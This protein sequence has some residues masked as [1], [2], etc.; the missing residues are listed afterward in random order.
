[1]I[2]LRAASI[3]LC[4]QFLQGCA[5]N[6]YFQKDALATAAENANTINPEKDSVWV[7]AGRHYDRNALHRFFWGNHNRHLWTMPVKVPVFNRQEV[8]AGLRI[9]KEGGGFQ[10]TS[11]HMQDSAGRAYAFRSIDKDP[12]HVLSPFWQS[13]FVAN[14]VR[15]QTSAANPFGMLLVP[16]LARAAGILH[17]N[18]RLFYVSQ[19]DTTFGEFSEQVQ[20]RLFMLEEKFKTAADIPE[21]TRGVKGFLDSDE[22]LRL[23]YTS[24]LYH[25]DQRAF[26]KARLLDLLL[27]DW[28]R[29]KGQW[30]WAVTQHGNKTIFNPIPKDRDQVLLKM[31]D[32]VIPFL[33]TSKIMV[34]KFY[35][36]SGKYG[37]VKALLINAQFVDERLLHELPKEEWLAIARQMQQAISDEVIAEAVRQLPSPI[38][39]TIGPEVTANLKKRRDHLPEAAEKMYSLLAKEV[40]IPGTDEAEQFIVNRLP[41]G[42]T[43]VRVY[44]R[45][46]ETLQEQLLYERIFQPKET[47][48][49]RLHGLA[50]ND[51]FVVEGYV[52]K[53]I[54]LEI[55]G[56]L[57]EDNIVDRSSVRGW[58]K[59]TAVFD[60]KRGN[61]IVPGTETKDRTTRDVSVHAYDREGN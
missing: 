2:F 43:H 9:I 26:A 27:G 58:K 50:G 32:G 14:I 57:G 37:D 59:T 28:D 40:T 56:G 48:L 5:D 52:D 7:I 42:K 44:R 1:M 38:R 54:P 8:A 6:D 31:K 13:T 39:K 33:A 47:R 61:K 53:A 36:F 46:S 30:D 51:E 16:P 23:R 15:D 29:H 18:P 55:V 21:N 25:F 10:T 60:T 3:L 35:T 49:I 19:N 4:A 22:A 41:E 34:R 45:M 17:S 20:G 12:V 24:N 11:F